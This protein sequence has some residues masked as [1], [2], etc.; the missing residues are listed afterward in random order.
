MNAV[1]AFSA[2]KNINASATFPGSINE[3]VVSAGPSTFQDSDALHCLDGP[4]E[5][6]RKR[7]KRRGSSRKNVGEAVGGGQTQLVKVADDDDGC[8]LALDTPN[9]TKDPEVEDGEVL[10]RASG[11]DLGQNSDEASL[12]SFENE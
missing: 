12:E 11:S 4:T 7:R 1:S 10:R 3:D 8:T 9:Q 6:P 5:P 2:R